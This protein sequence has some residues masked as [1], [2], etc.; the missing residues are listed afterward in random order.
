MCFSYRV[1]YS[2]LVLFYFPRYFLSYWSLSCGHG[3][4]CIV[5]VLHVKPFFLPVDIQYTQCPC[6]FFNPINRRD[7]SSVVTKLRHRYYVGTY[8]VPWYAVSTAV[9]SA[10][11]CH[12]DTTGTTY[13]FYEMEKRKETIKEKTKTKKTNRI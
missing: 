11:P 6:R 1:Y 13:I 5:C 10:M 7:T 8:Q 3:L 12:L 2:L 4:H 9:G